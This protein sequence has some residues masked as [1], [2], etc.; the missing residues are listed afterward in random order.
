MHYACVRTCK[1]ALEEER[2]DGVGGVHKQREKVKRREKVVQ[3]FVQFIRNGHTHTCTRE[4][5][6]SATHK[7]SAESNHK[8]KQT[9]RQ[10]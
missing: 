3:N 2:D 6:Q 5:I 10:I 8:K 1:F 9:D 7:H 4:T